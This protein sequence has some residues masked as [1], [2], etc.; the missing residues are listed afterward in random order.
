MTDNES[1]CPNCNYKLDAHTSVADGEIV[2]KEG[3]GS[4]CINCGE[5]LMFNADLKLELIT[6]E[7]LEE[8]EKESPAQF[9]MATMISSIIRAKYAAKN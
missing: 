5:I 6:N 9:K 2:P 8:F 3:D 4:V 7:R 1:Y